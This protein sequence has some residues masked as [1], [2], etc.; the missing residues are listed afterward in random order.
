MLSS[1]DSMRQNQDLLLMNEGSYALQ[2]A[3]CIHT[4]ACAIFSRQQIT[5]GSFA[6]LLST[7]HFVF[8][9]HQKGMLSNA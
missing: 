7:V 6:F 5:P 8:S 4:L 3:L 9:M 2:H 1:V